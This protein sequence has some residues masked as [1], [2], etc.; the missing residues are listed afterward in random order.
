MVHGGV[1]CKGPSDVPE[2]LKQDEATLLEGLSSRT[3]K[4]LA[5]KPFS[6]FRSFESLGDYL[7]FAQDCNP[8]MADAYKNQFD[9]FFMDADF[10]RQLL[11]G[12]DPTIIERITECLPD[13]FPVTDEL[14]AKSLLR[15]LSIEEEILRGNLYLVNYPNFTGIPRYCKKGTKR[16]LASPMALLY[17]NEED[18]L[19]PIAIKLSQ[20]KC[21]SIPIFTPQDSTEDWL[22][23]KMWVKN[24]ATQHQ[25]IYTMLTKTVFTLEAIAV[26][27]ERN[28]YALHPLYKLLKPSLKDA[29]S[30][31][32]TE[33]DNL[34]GEDGLA[35]RTMSLGSAGAAAYM[36]KCFKTFNMW[37]LVPGFD[38]RERKMLE[39]FP[40]YH[41]RHDSLATF[42]LIHKWVTS[43]LGRF[44]ATD[45]AVRA[46]VELQNM[47][48]DLHVNG[49]PVW[50]RGEGHGVPATFNVF[51][52]LA[53]FATMVIYNCS[54]GYAALNYPRAEFDVFIPNSP[55]AMMVHPPIA[56][57]RVTMET[58]IKA[59]PKNSVAVDR[60]SYVLSHTQKNIKQPR[61]KDY[62]NPFF[63]G[64]SNKDAIENFQ[65]RMLDL[66]DF[67]DKQNENRNS[68]SCL[69]PGKVPVNITM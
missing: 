65:R 40:N 3:A 55:S 18:D 45:G 31:S 2:I 51:G 41:W 43:F 13:N 56:K 5:S 24:A 61:M 28:L 58:I 36:K 48:K 47:V 54:F 46:D 25:Q 42:G 4:L 10:G 22:F 63:T 39:K 68:Y 8:A 35:D 12:A 29:V 64:K 67:L 62:E 19:V 23:A 21:D 1:V 16:Y 34:F 11:V 49:L 30:I 20:E 59:L 53:Q 50:N 38:L 52:Q 66:E 27:V 14:V 37:S 69:I 9:K 17:L 15:G 33:R 32:V 6:R 57:G 44:Y 7:T 60:V 26:A